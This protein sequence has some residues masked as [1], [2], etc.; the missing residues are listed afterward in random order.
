[1][2]TLFNPNEWNRSV[3]F[4]TILGL[5]IA[6]GFLD[7]GTSDK[8][9]F[10]LF[11]LV[12]IAMAFW[13]AGRNWGMATVAGCAMAWF[14][15]DAIAGSYGHG[16]VIYVCNAVVHFGF[17]LMVGLLLSV[18]Q[19]L[20]EKER[21][22]SRIDYL[23]HAISRSFFF[24]LIQMEIDRLARYRRPFSI[25]YLN[26]DDFKV[27]NERRG[28]AVGDQVL[29]LM[30]DCLRQHLR[31][32]DILA[33]LGGDEFAILLPETAR[34]EAEIVT[35]KLREQLYQSMRDRDFHVTFSVGVL[36]CIRT[37]E[38]VDDLISKA[39]ELMCEVKKLGKNGICHA[40]YSSDPL[41]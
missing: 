11:Y 5:I 8:I 9:S 24:D 27:I 28:H 25:M 16:I 4:A 6:I 33:R 36:T 26:L 10:E 22:Y 3:L 20:L 1:M 12:P 7:G 40:E 31:A 37:P 17:F 35:V 13:Y 18:L 14:A 2:K 23:T 32:T 41:R 15:G 38:S 39:D 29:C 30:V 21:A 19:R 34:A